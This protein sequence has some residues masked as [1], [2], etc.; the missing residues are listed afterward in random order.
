MWTYVFYR[1]KALI[2]IAFH[3]YMFPS[4]SR[5][6]LSISDAEILVEFEKVV[7]GNFELATD[8]LL[9]RSFSIL[10]SLY[11]QF[12]QREISLNSTKETALLLQAVC[13]KE[14]PL[15][16]KKLDE[17]LSDENFKRGLNGLEAEFFV[18]SIEIKKFKESPPLYDRIYRQAKKFYFALHRD[19][20]DPDG[21]IMRALYVVPDETEL[22]RELALSYFHIKT[23]PAN[24]KD[25]Y[26]ACLH[27]VLKCYDKG[28]LS[29][30]IQPPQR[31][32]RKKNNSLH[33]FITTQL[34][35]LAKKGD[36]SLPSKNVLYKTLKKLRNDAR[37]WAHFQKL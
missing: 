12:Q 13:G 29:D 18:L 4:F 5:C 1:T 30:F 9:E 8:E 22:Q 7:E 34:N 20:L 19:K 2:N 28:M 16:Y 15:D 33:D 23:S 3:R 10:R 24:T 11:S 35:K 6:Q 36:V 32:G 17:T 25:I 37:V 14:T 26:D 27:I 21:K 31:R